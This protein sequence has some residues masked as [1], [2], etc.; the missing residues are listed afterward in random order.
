MEKL[1]ADLVLRVLLFLRPSEVTRMLSVDTRFFQVVHD[2][3][4]WR[5]LCTLSGTPSL[6]K[7]LYDEKLNNSYDSCRAYQLLARRLQACSEMSRVQWLKLQ[8]ADQ[9]PGSILEKMEAHTATTFLNRFVVV[10]GGWCRANDNGVHVIDASVLCNNSDSDSDSASNGDTHH[11]LVTL[12]TFTKNRPTFRYGFSTTEYQGRLLVLGGC[13]SG[14]YSHDCN[15]LYFV[16]LRFD[17]VDENGLKQ[18]FYPNKLYSNGI[19]SE[20]NRTHSTDARQE[21]EHGDPFADCAAL[22]S[23]PSGTEYEVCRHRPISLQCLL[24]LLIAIYNHL[25]GSEVHK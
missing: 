11:P 22:K 23:H 25:G 6:H 14:G 24:F 16:D 1:S 15:N 9:N 12:A 17:R 10:V 3:Y 19:P 21:R 2:Q 18:S 4:L 8:Y 7:S 20:G 5:N 13:Q